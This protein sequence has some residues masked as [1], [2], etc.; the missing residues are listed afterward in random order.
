MTALRGVLVVMQCIVVV[1]FFTLFTGCGSTADDQT[2]RSYNSGSHIEI[3]T[4]QVMLSWEQQV[5]NP[6]FPHA[7]NVIHE[8]AYNG[9]DS[10]AVLID[11][12]VYGPGYE[13]P[14]CYG[15]TRYE[16][17]RSREIT[18]RDLTV[19]VEYADHQRIVFTVVHDA[20]Q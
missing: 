7:S 4:G 16:M 20:H 15:N 17:A 5:T 1:L 3:Q 11:H 19:R 2:C 8:L 12:K 10:G 6:L 18:I 13:R 9:V 14:V